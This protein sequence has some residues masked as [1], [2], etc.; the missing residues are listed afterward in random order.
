MKKEEEK[1]Y[2]IFTMFNPF[3]FGT[4]FW[5]TLM[6]NWWYNVG[7]DFAMD[8]VKMSKYWYDAYIENLNEFF[9]ILNINNSS[10]K[11]HQKNR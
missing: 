5:Q 11:S 3:V 8:P 4:T 2:D 9:P 7:R 6:T 10:D 1:E